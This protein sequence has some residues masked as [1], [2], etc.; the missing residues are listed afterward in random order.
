MSEQPDEPESLDVSLPLVAAIAVVVVGG[1]MAI[2]WYGIPGPTTEY[3]LVS[4]SGERALELAERCGETICDRVAI[5]EETLPD[6]EVERLECTLNIEAKVPIFVEINP[7]WS[8]DETQMT[9]DYSNPDNITGS[10]T[11]NFAQD[12]SPDA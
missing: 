6:L 7:K 12:C 9:I 11:L 1:I 4:P 2:I 10:I 5:F 3:R 8:G